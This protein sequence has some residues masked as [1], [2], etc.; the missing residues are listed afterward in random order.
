MQLHSLSDLISFCDLIHD[1][2]VVIDGSQHITL[3]N[4]GAE[5][6]F[7]H[8]AKKALG[9]DISMLLPLGRRENNLA[10][11]N[12]F[13]AASSRRRLASERCIIQGLNKSGE[14]F[15]AEATLS[16][17]HLGTDEWYMAVIQKIDLEK[18]IN[19]QA[20]KNT[21][22]NIL[23][24]TLLNTAL[25]A[26][27][28]TVTIYDQHGN[29][30][31]ADA[32]RKEL[33]K[34]LGLG[35]KGRKYT[36]IEM[37]ESLFAN[38]PD[39]AARTADNILSLL[40]G[41]RKFFEIEYSLTLNDVP[42]C[43]ITTGS[44][45]PQP[46]GGA[47]LVSLDVTERTERENEI[48]IRSQAMDATLT[49]IA[50]T[51][52]DGHITYAN[53]ALLELWGGKSINDV[54]NINLSTMWEN[55]QGLEGIIKHIQ[56]TGSW[57][58]HL[59]SKGESGRPGHYVYAKSSVIHRK[60][61][62]FLCV[63]SSFNDLTER[64]KAETAVRQRTE[65]MM[66]ITDT[67]PFM[68]TYIDE[69]MQLTFMNS[70]FEKNFSLLRETAL[71][72]DFKACVPIEIWHLYLPHIQKSLQGL[73]ADY[74]ET[75]SLPDQPPQILKSLF[76]PHMEGEKAVGVFLIMENV[77]TQR[78]E[79]AEEWRSRNLQSLGTLAGG[80]AHD[81]NN[82]LTPIIG[83]TEMVMD[84][85]ADDQNSRNLEDV[86]NAAHRA[87]NLV[88]QILAFSRNN[89]PNRRAISLPPLIEDTILLLRVNLPDNIKINQHI[90]ISPPI[91]ADEIQMQQIIFNLCSNATQAM[92]LKGGIL[93]ISLVTDI[94]DRCFFEKHPKTSP[95]PYL[96]LTI[97][98]TGCGME[99]E[100]LDRIFDPFFTTKQVGNGTGMGLSVVHGIVTNHKGV[101]EVESAPDAGT[102]VNIY[103][104][105]AAS[106]PAPINPA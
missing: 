78:Q 32:K 47:I 9:K 39:L 54:L 89:L 81:I 75:V 58:G 37:C 57:S 72:K 65:Q 86:L 8:A 73:R 100:T 90:Q 61:G 3:Y 102:S 69:N 82:L 6:L 48:R 97:S 70:A 28:V 40:D 31:F 60:D 104:P 46:N 52:M 49:P 45:L 80:I 16:K 2:V 38:D 42:H 33:N 62:S 95:G 44:S 53:K 87:S 1:A 71:G 88:G 79:E 20:A 55:G 106:Q 103:L 66:L 18:Q 64:L 29:A 41:R 83:L 50:M 77:T 22:E 4:K 13:A 84:N 93:N 24:T 92:G 14:I 91:D 43:F 68:V 56:A 101:I 105:V 85:L 5:T 35:L 11:V 63:V 25:D 15:A 10:L 74:E 19:R 94:P 30:V 34:R 21:S 27:P 67:L 7:G 12:E 51:D 96:K 23:H 76:L 59:V 26:S 99:K 98:D 17:I 36:Y